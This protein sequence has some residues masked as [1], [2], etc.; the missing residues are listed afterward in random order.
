[1]TIEP[2]DPTAGDA[3][4]RRRL[5]TRRGLL[6]LVAGG[7]VAAG[8]GLYFAAPERYLR[9]LLAR[10]L[11]GVRLDPEG[12][13][14]FEE[15]MLS[16]RLDAP[17]DR[18]LAWGLGPASWV[19][20]VAP[21]KVRRLREDFDRKALTFFLNG[22]DFFAYENPR[23]EVIGYYGALDMCATNPFA[24]FEDADEPVVVAATA[25]QIR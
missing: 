21:E 5:P 17:R 19:D 23:E 20:P 13:A 16:I 6:K 15:E 8:A 22:S 12:V 3:A 1:M 7:A 18:L 14:L 9:D 25:G 24:V 2:T 4:E 11:P 10:A